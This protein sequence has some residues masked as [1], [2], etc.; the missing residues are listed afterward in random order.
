MK[1]Q[2][3]VFWNVGIWNSDAGELPARKH[4]TFRTRRKFE[5]KNVLALFRHIQGGVQQIK[6]I[7]MANYNTDVQKYRILNYLKILKIRVQNVHCNSFY[8]TG[9]QTSI[10]ANRL[11]F[12]GCVCVSIMHSSIVIST[13]TGDKGTCPWKR[14]AVTDVCLQFK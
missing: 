12:Q 6:N 11:C 3:T 13:T 4:T 7:Q 9:K 10:A 2:Q 1:T 8:W 5:I 14:T